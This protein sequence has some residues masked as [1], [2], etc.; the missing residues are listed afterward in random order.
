MKKHLI[1]ER[2]RKLDNTA[3][4][5][6]LDDKKN[7]STF[8]YSV[9]LK[10][11]VNPKI[12][13]KAVNKTLDEIPTFKVKKGTGLFWNYIET[14]KK[15]IKVEEENEIPCEHINLRKNNNYLFKITYYKNKIN[16]DIFHILTDGLG[17]SILLKGIIYNYL[18]IKYKIPNEITKENEIANYK[19]LYLK[20]SDK[21]KFKKEKKQYAYQIP[22]KPSRRINNTYH[23]NISVKELKTICKNNNVTITEY[24][25]ALYIY[26]IYKSLYDKKSNKEIVVSVPINL[27]TV[28]NEHTLANFFT[29]MKVNSNVVGKE[30]VTFHEVLEYTHNEFKEKLTK[31]KIESYLARDVRIGTNI[32][33]RLAPLFLK[34]LFIK[35]FGFSV[36][37]QQTTMLSNVGNVEI[38]DK[39]KIYIDNILV[40]A[41][42]NRLQQTKCTICSY[43]DKLN[44]TLNLNINNQTLPNYFLKQLKSSVKNIEVISNK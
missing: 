42:P 14:N 19:D 11:D 1:K 10:K 44:I 24:I 30:K 35:Y 43:Q 31:D 38:D 2:W 17:A 7:T 25:T 28:Y 22:D 23:Y 29:Y 5:F 16:I 13:Q 6:S 9:L 8:R 26:S 27:R 3:K 4:M 18:S 33:I 39:F 34:K 12:L 15:T 40:A 37:R 20:Y 32:F 36:K 41:M 21:T